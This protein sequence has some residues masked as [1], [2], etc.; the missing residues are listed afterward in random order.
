MYF[1]NCLDSVESVELIGSSIKGFSEVIIA[2]KVLFLELEISRSLSSVV[3]VVGMIY[4]VSDIESMFW[5]L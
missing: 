4:G 3:H 2:G 5:I 1:T